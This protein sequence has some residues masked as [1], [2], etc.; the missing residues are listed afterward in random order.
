M[1]VTQKYEFLITNQQDCD[2]YFWYV[3]QSTWEYI[4]L[5]TCTCFN[6]PYLDHCISCHGLESVHVLEM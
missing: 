3:P 2:Q 6:T 1:S 5:F 4:L